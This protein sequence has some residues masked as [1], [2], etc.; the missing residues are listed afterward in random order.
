MFRAQQLQRKN[1]MGQTRTY[2]TLLLGRPP[3]TWRGCCWYS[4]PEVEQMQHPRFPT[5]SPVGCTPATPAA[6]SARAPVNRMKPS[7]IS[8]V[9][10]ALLV[11]TSV[12]AGTTL[13][14]WHSYVHAQTHQRHYSF[15]LVQCKRGMFWGSCG[16]STKSL[17]WSFTFDLA[18][19]GPVYTAKEISISDDNGQ[20]LPVVSGQVTATAKRQTIK[21]ALWIETAGRTNNFV[22]N[23]NYQIHELK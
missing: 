21:I 9:V 11:A 18:G 5:E 14:F 20:A 19:D 6:A 16:P 4:V 23:G 3:E 17:Q 7:R 15:H 2:R 10:S 22:G 8:L 13:D 12:L 1:D